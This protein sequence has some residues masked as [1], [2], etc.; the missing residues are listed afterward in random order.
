MY[1]FGLL[2]VGLDLL[3]LRN[4]GSNVSVGGHAGGALAGLAFLLA[5]RRGKFPMRWGW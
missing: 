3:T 1:A 2:W 5:H 4:P